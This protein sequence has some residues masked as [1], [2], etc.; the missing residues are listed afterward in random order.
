MKYETYQIESKGRPEQILI[1]FFF[2]FFC[3]GGGERDGSGGYSQRNVK[4]SNPALFH[5]PY[6]INSP[7]WPQ[8]RGSILAHPRLRLEKFDSSSFTQGLKPDWVHLLGTMFSSSESETKL[9]T[10]PLFRRYSPSFS[11]ETLEKDFPGLHGTSHHH[12]LCRV[13][14]TGVGSNC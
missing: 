13:F 3:K 2:F 10:A 12:F 9:V 7:S 6:N 4:L 5:V 8:Q 14:L 11:R 1:K